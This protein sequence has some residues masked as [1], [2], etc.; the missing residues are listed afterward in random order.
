[1][2]VLRWFMKTIDQLD[3][4]GGFNITITTD[5]PCHLWLRWTDKQPWVHRRTVI[6]RGL[7]VPWLSYFCFAAW[8][9]I[10]Q[11]EA[12]D[13]TTHTFTWLG[14]QVCQR[15][16]FCFSGTRQG[17]KSPSDSP[18]FWKHYKEVAPM[19]YVIDIGKFTEE[20]VLF[21]HVKLEQGEN[22]TITRNDPNNSLIISALTYELPDFVLFKTNWTKATFGTEPVELPSFSFDRLTLTTKKA[23]HDLRV[24]TPQTLTWDFRAP[25][26]MRLMA[27]RDANA[28]NTMTVYMA[29]VLDQL[30][31]HGNRTAKHIAFIHRDNRLRFSCGNG[32]AYTEVAGEVGAL[33]S[34]KQ[35]KWVRTAT[36]VE[37]YQDNVLQATI[38]TNVPPPQN[39]CRFLFQ[40]KGVADVAR[41]FWASQPRLSGD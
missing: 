17:D 21:D 15:K 20:E 3:I 37:F 27:L 30:N 22:I 28:A 34:I 33:S 19:I 38:T 1:M 32:T 4:P 26:V 41:A 36:G 6:Q 8:L 13:T 25:H 24:Y 23:D 40:G 18:I 16:Y 12:G 35:L 2:S 14:W 9:A 29:M 10:E 5:V 39:N 7:R 31:L 11:Q